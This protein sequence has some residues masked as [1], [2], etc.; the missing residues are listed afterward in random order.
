MSEWRKLAVFAGGGSLPARLAEATRARGR[1]VHVFRLAGFADARMQQFPGEDCAIGEV[2]K[3]ADVLKAQAC[4][5]AVFAGLVQRPDFSSLKVDLAG[6]KLL[7]KLIA[8]AARGDGAL[9][10]VLVERVEAEGVKVVGA[11]D[12]LKGLAAPAGAFGRV[13]PSEKDRA[14]LRKAAAVIAALG[15]FDV[16]QAA[17]VARGLVLAI[18]AAE[19]T[20]AM[21]ARCEGLPDA[22]R[23]GVL[24][25]RPKPGQERRVDLP[26]IGPET[27]KRARAAGL[28]GIAVEAEGALIVDRAEVARLADE[29][30]LFV[31]GFKPDEIEA[32]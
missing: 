27:V 21:L 7:P 26:V 2:G 14:D 17:V 3:I 4:D 28:A 23:G 10:K 9:L 24:V 29:A 32:V 18:E 25:K 20:D 19:G 15:S 5:A 13:R 30:Q 12:V 31:Y 11:E 6:A 8:A 16:G 1:L 22:V